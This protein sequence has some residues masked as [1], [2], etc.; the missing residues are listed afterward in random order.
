MPFNKTQYEAASE[1]LKRESSALYYKRKKRLET[2]NPEPIEALKKAARKGDRRAVLAMIDV[3]YIIHLAKK[4]PLLDIVNLDSVLVGA[5]SYAAVETDLE[6]YRG[7]VDEIATRALDEYI[8]TGEPVD[9]AAV[10]R[11]MQAVK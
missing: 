5:T 1:R 7:R 11:A 10:I 8:T 6:E 4:R 2:R 3:D 9:I